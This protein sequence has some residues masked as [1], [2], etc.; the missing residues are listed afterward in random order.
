MKLRNK[1]LAKIKEMQQFTQF[2]NT[3]DMQP[4][5]LNTLL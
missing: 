2:A 5:S 4:V 1:R 3:I